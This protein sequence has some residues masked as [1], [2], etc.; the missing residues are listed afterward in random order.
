[1][2]Y[3]I[4]DG[5]HYLFEKLWSIDQFRT[6]IDDTFGRYGWSILGIILEILIFNVIS[7]T[8]HE[9]N[10]IIE[11]LPVTSDIS[12][13]EQIHQ[14]RE[15][16]VIQPLVVILRLQSLVSFSYLSSAKRVLIKI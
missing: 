15:E 3:Q 12:T 10:G 14:F 11:S 16:N 7:S 9:D 6:S 4:D 13:K 8:D 2:K 5:K 1:M